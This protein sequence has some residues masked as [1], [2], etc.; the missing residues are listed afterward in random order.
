MVVVFS[1]KKKVFFGCM[2]AWRNEKTMATIKRNELLLG[3]QVHVSTLRREEFD[4]V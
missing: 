1:V 4:T 3:H 2:I